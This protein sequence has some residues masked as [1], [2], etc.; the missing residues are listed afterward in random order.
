MQGITEFDRSKLRSTQ[1]LVTPKDG[2]QFLDTAD[3]AVPVAGPADSPPG[4][5]TVRQQA[6]REGWD[7]NLPV[8]KNV[9]SNWTP[10]LDPSH[11]SPAAADVAAPSNKRDIC[12]ARA[13]GRGLRRGRSSGPTVGSM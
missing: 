6:H 8:E 5:G 2:R 1:T 13:A 9:D 10:L 12:V 4:A 7:P 11:P 3:G